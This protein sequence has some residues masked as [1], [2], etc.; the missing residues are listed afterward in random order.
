[1]IEGSS[2]CLLEPSTFAP[3]LFTMD[4]AVRVDAARRMEFLFEWL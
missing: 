4:R 1:M 3:E 2:D